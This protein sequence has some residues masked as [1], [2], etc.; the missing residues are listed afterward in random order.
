M[1]KGSLE[2]E[3]ICVHEVDLALMQQSQASTEK[4]IDTILAKLNNMPTK[5]ALHEQSISKLWKVIWIFSVVIIGGV[6]TATATAILS[7]P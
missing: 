2:L 5:I 1:E 4:K 7:N 3:H 6:V